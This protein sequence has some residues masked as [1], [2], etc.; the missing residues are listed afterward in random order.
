MTHEIGHT[1]NLDHKDMSDKAEYGQ[2][3][4]AKGF[5]V[6]PRRDKPKE[7]VDVRAVRHG[8]VLM[9]IKEKES[10][11]K[12]LENALKKLYRKKKYYE[13]VMAKTPSGQQ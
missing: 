1:I 10:R 4:W 13:R 2:S 6:G 9:L 3:E 8:R 7:K 5:A 12:R 11:L